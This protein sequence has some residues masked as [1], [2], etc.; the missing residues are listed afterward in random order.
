MAI[1]RKLGATLRKLPWCMMLSPVLRIA[2]LTAISVG[3]VAILWESYWTEST[4]DLHSSYWPATR[5]WL[6]ERH[7]WYTA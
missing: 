2:S 7:P 4:M 5:S 3:V 1:S 6:V